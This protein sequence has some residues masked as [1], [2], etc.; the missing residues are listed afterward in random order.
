METL[1]L[2]ATEK[3]KLGNVHMHVKTNKEDL[4]VLYLNQ[5]QFE[6]FSNILKSGCFNKNVDLTITDP[7]Y[8]NEEDNSSLFFQID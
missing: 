8:D 7:F 4:G 2:V 3:T 6:A 5:E 1:E